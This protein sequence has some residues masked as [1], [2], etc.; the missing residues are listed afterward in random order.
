MVAIAQS[1]RPLMLQLANEVLP[2][3]GIFRQ[4]TADEKIGL[5]RAIL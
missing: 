3:D 2:Q 4:F 1:D 5:V